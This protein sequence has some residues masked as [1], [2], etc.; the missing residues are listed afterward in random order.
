MMLPWPYFENLDKKKIVVAF[1]LGKENRNHVFNSLFSCNFLMNNLSILL[2][3][4]FVERD[5]TLLL[6]VVKFL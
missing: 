4:I 5:L 2:S 6:K 3:F 1:I